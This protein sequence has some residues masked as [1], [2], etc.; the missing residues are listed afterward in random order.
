MTSYVEYSRVWRPTL[1]PEEW[2]LAN[3]INWAGTLE[4]IWARL[5][6]KADLEVLQPLRKETVEKTGQWPQQLELRYSSRDKEKHR[7]PAYLVAKV[8][9]PFPHLM[10]T[11]NSYIPIYQWIP[12]LAKQFGI[13]LK[14]R[15]KKQETSSEDI[16]MI[17]DVLWTRAK[18][19]D[20]THNIR[21]A[22]HCS[23]LLAAIGGWRPGCLVDIKYKQVQLA[24]VRHLNKTHLVAT[25]T[26]N[27]NKTNPNQIERTQRKT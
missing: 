16:I 10:F 12:Q 6:R 8:R 15:F 27:Q 19:I 25:I 5:I 20:C 24:W 13:S 22:F 14:Q 26:I 11:R 23:I 18:D 1:G 21:V 9:Q 4:D 2:V 7:S 3:T 17:L